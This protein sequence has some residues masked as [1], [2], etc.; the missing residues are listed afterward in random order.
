M[1][2]DRC[3]SWASQLK[4]LK[5]IH[6]QVRNPTNTSTVSGYWLQLV[7]RLQV[8]WCYTPEEVLPIMAYTG[9]LRPKMVPF[10]GFG[11]IGTHSTDTRL[12]YNVY[13]GQFRMS[14][15]KLHFFPLKSICLI[16][17][18]VNTDNAHFSLSRVTLSYTCIIKPALQTLLCY[19]WLIVYDKIQ[20]LT[21][22]SLQ[23]WRITF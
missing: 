6:I 19:L 2:F 23:K 1:Y 7:S 15:R 21:V 9:S 18:P 3:Y 5:H 4:H 13:N 11:Y 22:T 20:I 14:Q 12:I 16:Q 17:T 10:S 8:A